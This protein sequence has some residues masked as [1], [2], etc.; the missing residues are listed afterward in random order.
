MYLFKFSSRIYRIEKRI[1]VLELGLRYWSPGLVWLT[2]LW[3]C[4]GVRYI[5]RGP[6]GPKKP[7]NAGIMA[8]CLKQ[9]PLFPSITSVTHSPFYKLELSKLLLYFLFVKLK[10]VLRTKNQ[11]IPINFLQSGSSSTPSHS[12][13]CCVYENILAH[14]YIDVVQNLCLF[15]FTGRSRV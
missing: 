15:S 1:H 13:Y 10:S 6:R 9:P 2:D 3:G 4:T 12:G 14:I 8:Q 11:L 7:K 5:L